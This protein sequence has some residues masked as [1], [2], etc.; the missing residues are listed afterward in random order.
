LTAGQPQGFQ[1]TL[2]AALAAM[3]ALSTLLAV[4]RAGENAIIAVHLW[5]LA[6]LV[7]C[8]TKRRSRKPRFKFLAQQFRLR[9]SPSGLAY[10]TAFGVLLPVGCL[11]MDPIVF[12][13]NGIDGPGVFSD[14]RIFGYW[15][16]ALQVLL[17]VCWLVISA[18]LIRRLRGRAWLGALT[19]CWGGALLSGAVFALLLGFVLLPLS[20]LGLAVL[21]GVLGYTPLLTSFAY[22]RNGS[23][24][25]RIGQREIGRWWA[26]VW[27]LSGSTA[28]IS[29][30][31]ANAWWQTAS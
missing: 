16:I 22:L 21:I 12:T 20:T 8:V 27:A 28:I 7:L 1:F 17:L 19:A 2:A 26:S 10:D 23:V 11:L 29:P 13:L 15:T 14:L 6:A 4:T 5:L 31:L 24:A 9:P 3:T 25:L 30:W 18:Q